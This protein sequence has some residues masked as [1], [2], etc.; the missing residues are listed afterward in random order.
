MSWSVIPMVQMGKVNCPVLQL[1]D[2]VSKPRQSALKAAY[3]F[4]NFSACL[5]KEN[6]YVD[7]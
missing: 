3:T 1:I 4:S 5:M 2:G 7:V 6:I